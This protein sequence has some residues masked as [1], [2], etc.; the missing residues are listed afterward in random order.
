MNVTAAEQERWAF[1]P[2]HV[3]GSKGA[4]EQEVIVEMTLAG[5]H[6]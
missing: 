4:A 6:L 1:A 5:L 3:E 2:R